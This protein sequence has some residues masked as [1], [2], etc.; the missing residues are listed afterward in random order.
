MVR[1]AYETRGGSTLFSIFLAKHGGERVCCVNLLRNA[2]GQKGLKYVVPCFF[3]PVGFLGVFGCSRACTQDDVETEEEEEKEEEEEGGS[4]RRRRRRREKKRRK[5]RNIFLR[6]VVLCFFFVCLF[7]FP[8]RTRRKKRRRR[9]RRK[10]SEE[11]E[12]AAEKE[13]KKK[14][15]SKTQGEELD[16][17]GEGEELGK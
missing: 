6:V 5:R 11:E 3:S 4:R 13:E 1:G 14:K 17:E 10:F 2:G 15:R 9:R 8:G 7:L 16:K 12:E